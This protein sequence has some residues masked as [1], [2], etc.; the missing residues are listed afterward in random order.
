M[1][2]RTCVAG[3]GAYKYAELFKQR[4]GLVLEKEDEM[5][6]LVAG[7]N[8]LLKAITHEAFRYENS[9]SSFVPTT[10]ACGWYQ[11][12]SALESP[13]TS[14]VLGASALGLANGNTGSSTACTEVATEMAPWSPDIANI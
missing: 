8:F 9:T 11:G 3:G 4:L 6:C 14:A 2:T 13:L 7:C 12:S 5:H 10:G 1:R